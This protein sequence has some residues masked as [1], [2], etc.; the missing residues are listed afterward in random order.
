MEATTAPLWVN[1]LVQVIVVAIILL[2]A[3]VV[4]RVSQWPIRR[5]LSKRGREHADGTVFF[6][7]IRVLVWGTAA[8]WIIDLVFDVDM[9][10]FLG[11]AG[12]V[13]IAVSLGAQQTIA[14]IIG[15]IIVSLSELVGPGDWISVGGKKE[16]RII[17]TDWRRTLLEDE[18]SV[19]Y[20]VPNSVMVSS[21]VTKCTPFLVFIVPFAIKP[22]TPDVE[23]LLV[24]CEQAI[25]DRLI[26]AELDYEQMRPKA[27][28]A[29]SNMFVINAE[30]KVYSSRARDTRFIE[31]AVLPGL[32]ELLQER[33]V[34]S[35]MSKPILVE[36]A[37]NGVAEEVAVIEDSLDA[38]DVP[39]I[40]AEEVACAP[41]SASDVLEETASREAED[42]PADESV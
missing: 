30:V 8:C 20:V 28:I 40:E 9:V 21:I 16:G 14:N 37:A 13:G 42:A 18:D 26:L 2:L 36:H 5:M 29:G 17:K 11:A 27:H 7:I 39:S 19:Q 33:G 6:N 1:I 3:L 23:G 15:G 4:S 24:D 10:G 41:A 12:I 25:L 38:P 35:G 34:L 22:D 32:I 31:R